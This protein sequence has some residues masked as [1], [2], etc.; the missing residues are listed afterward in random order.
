[1]RLYLES[2]SYVGETIS[3]TA[4]MLSDGKL[5]LSM[6]QPVDRNPAIPVHRI[7]S[8]GWVERILHLQIFFQP[9]EW[10]S[11]VYDQPVEIRLYGMSLPVIEPLRID[12]EVIHK[13]CPV[14]H[15]GMHP[16]RIKIYNPIKGREVKITFLVLLRRGITPSIEF[17]GIK[18]G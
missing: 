14:G 16:A 15:F 2:N 8:P 5:I 13:N 17:V 11:N 4:I 1:M 18:P 7:P 9:I 3:R 6:R 12:E 10:S